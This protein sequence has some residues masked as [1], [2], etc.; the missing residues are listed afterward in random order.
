MDRKAIIL[1][2]FILLTLVMS[3]PA[4]EIRLRRTPAAP[5]RGPDGA[6]APVAGAPSVVRGDEITPRQ[7]EAVEKGLIWLANHQ[8]RDGSYGGDGMGRHA[9]ITGLAG[10]AFMQAGNLPNRGKYG[11]N[12]NKC[13]DFVLSASQESGLISGDNSQGPMYGHGFAT[14]F[15]AELYGM[16][17][18][19]R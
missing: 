17:G 4:Q 8:G 7:K 18:D 10:L 11:E 2:G 12:V 1:V 6:K 16:T 13:L 3:S 9:G 14:L 5:P 15:L 19:D